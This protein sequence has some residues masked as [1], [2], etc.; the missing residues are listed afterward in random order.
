M[1][2]LS[3]SRIE[4]NTATDRPIQANAFAW[5][6]AEF[7][8]VERMRILAAA[9][10]HA[11]AHEIVFETDFDR[12]WSFV[13]DLEANTK[14]YEALVSKLVIRSR[15]GEKLEVDS[16]LLPGLTQRLDVVLR[17]GWCLMQSRWGEIGM[18]A[19]PESPTQT[20]FIHFERAKVASRL[21]RP[22]FDLNIRHDFRKLSALLSAK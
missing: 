15:S 22:L 20:R 11:A 16:Q 13:A 2:D 12:L 8:P 1:K 14:R 18:A 21:L 3:D 5:P 9:L 6:S 7:D 19:R 4:A 17:P 10:P